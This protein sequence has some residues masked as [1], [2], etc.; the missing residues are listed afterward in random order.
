MILLFKPVCAGKRGKAVKKG[1]LVAPLILVAACGLGKAQ[2]PL[3]DPAN[4]YR[5]ASPATDSGAKGSAQ[6]S[7]LKNT[8]PP[9][10][11]SAA[12]PTNSATGMCQPGC[13]DC[14][15]SECCQT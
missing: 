10:S 2:S 14:W 1:A 15:N 7:D 12:S 3:D 13:S 4:A 6:I 5:Y 11:W 8:P 9:P